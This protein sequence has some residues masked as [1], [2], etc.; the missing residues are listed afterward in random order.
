M[1][2]RAASSRV[3]AAGAASRGTPVIS[4]AY[5]A[6]PDW[7][8]RM[9]RMV[10]FKKTAEELRERELMA[11]LFSFLPRLV[12][13]EHDQDAIAA[14][15]EH[16]ANSYL[17]RTSLYSRELPITQP[18]HLQSMKKAFLPHPALPVV[19]ECSVVAVCDYDYD[20]DRGQPL[21]HAY[22]GSHASIQDFRECHRLPFQ[23]TQTDAPLSEPLR[24]QPGGE[25][26]EKH[27][28]PYII[29]PTNEAGTHIRTT[30]VV[31][32]V[33]HIHWRLDDTEDP[34]D[35]A[36]PN[37]DT[38]SDGITRILPY[39]MLPTQVRER[40]N[41]RNDL[42]DQGRYDPPPDDLQAQ[43]RSMV[44][45]ATAPNTASQPPWTSAP[46]TSP[47]YKQAGTPLLPHTFTIQ[48]R[49][50][51]LPALLDDL[52][53]A[54]TQLV[55]AG[56]AQDFIEQNILF[57]QNETVN[58]GAPS[59]VGTND[60]YLTLLNPRAGTT[61]PIKE[62]PPTDLSGIE[63]RSD[64]DRFLDVCLQP[65]RYLDPDESK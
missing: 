59:I 7:T 41:T 57:A 34:R 56:L 11:Y 20:Y 36:Q 9:S 24:D 3:P 52:V 30:T 8:P 22:L 14:C 31:L 1:S 2:A 16:V 10:L 64:R 45:S 12:L 51:P 49:T 17:R 42:L 28:Q 44:Y 19:L 5:Q 61:I 37:V 33:T 58:Q 62:L 48:G 53:Y 60:D 40:V 21:A 54:H 50:L 46:V 4:Y 6:N 47:A 43:H 15:F 38:T 27:T 32:R 35:V 23:K 29:A 13:E 65:T 39:E 25:A 26:R 18:I 63:G 55:I